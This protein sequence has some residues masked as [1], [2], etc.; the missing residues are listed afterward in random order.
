MKVSDRSL[1]EFVKTDNGFGKV[2][3]HKLIINFCKFQESKGF[4]APPLLVEL[5]TMECVRSKNTVNIYELF[6][7]LQPEVCK[8]SKV[9]QE[10]GL[11][12]CKDYWQFSSSDLLKTL[13]A[14]I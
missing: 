1:L 10:C 11:I 3:K 2:F 14:I 12:L 6:E 8:L 4:E 5:L 9:Q 7:K 13:K